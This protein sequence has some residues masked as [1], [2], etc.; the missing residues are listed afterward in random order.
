MDSHVRIT[1]G[2]SSFVK[3]N[4]DLLEN[5]SQSNNE[6]STNH[7]NTSLLSKETS[8][9]SKGNYGG[10]GSHHEGDVSSKLVVS[11]ST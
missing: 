6:I 5:G 1:Y 7:L 9:L 8:K 3:K 4:D 11:S 10:S 2:K